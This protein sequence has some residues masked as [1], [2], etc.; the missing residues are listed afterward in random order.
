MWGK[1]VGDV[2]TTQGARLGAVYTRGD[3]AVIKLCE[4]SDICFTEPLF[5]SS[6]FTV[7]LWLKHRTVYTDNHTIRQLF[8]GIGDYGNGDY[9]FSVFQKNH[10]T[11]EHLAVKVSAS[12]RTCTSIFPVPRS[13]WSL[14]TFVWNATDLNVYRNGLKVK[15]F[16]SK[17]CIDEIPRTFQHPTVIL[18][19]DAMFDDLQIWNRAL[20]PNEIGE[21]FT[22]IRGNSNLSIELSWIYLST[23]WTFSDF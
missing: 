23:V 22:C 5:C 21:M 11:E 9:S 6:G 10:R 7:S 2:G 14:F 12:S 4:V 19:G 17:Y 1:I 3:G 8:V 13:V 16:L 20:T 18:K 15:E